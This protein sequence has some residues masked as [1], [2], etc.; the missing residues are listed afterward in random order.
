MQKKKCEVRLC[1]C[2]LCGALEG[3]EGTSH[4]TLIQSNLDLTW[5]QVGQVDLFWTNIGGN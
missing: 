2:S 5:A 1:P 4:V 3:S